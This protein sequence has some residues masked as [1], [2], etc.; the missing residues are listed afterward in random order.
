MR[1]GW[2]KRQGRRFLL[3]ASATTVA[4][5]A[6]GWFTGIRDVMHGALISL[7]AAALLPFA[8]IAGVLFVLVA[9]AILVTVP[10]AVAGAEPPEVGAL[11]EASEPVAEAGFRLIGPYYR[12]IGRR[13]HPVFWGIP[14][15]VLLGG[16]LLWGVITLVIVPGE[17]RT[18]EKL[19]RARLAIETIYKQTGSL[20]KPS[21]HGH[22]VIE[23]TTFVDGF[24]RPV[25]YV[26]SG[27][28]KL[29]SWT[30]SSS[31]FDTD[32]RDDD[33]CVE[34]QTGVVKWVERA[35]AV[36]KLLDDV[37][38]KAVSTQ[39]RLAG[40]RALRCSS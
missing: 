6:L 9:L 24:D 7:L 19:A 20:P 14:A 2:W 17:T 34:G 38:G 21:E 31:G 30:L 27:T 26:V 36:K 35:R 16:L 13:R 12:F 33:L 40:I 25:T 23:G 1:H 32:D 5:V 37:I 11:A 10:A 8:I 15:G 28:W 22:L 39:E 18:V 4:V 3:A 29:A